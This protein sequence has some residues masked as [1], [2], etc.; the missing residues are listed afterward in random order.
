MNRGPLKIQKLLG[1]DIK[2]SNILDSSDGSC[3]WGFLNLILPICIG[4]LKFDKGRKY[5]EIVLIIDVGK[6]LRV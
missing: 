5:G 4:L 3:F 2:Q 1:Q 6:E